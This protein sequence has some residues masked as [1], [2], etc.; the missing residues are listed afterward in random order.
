LLD[1]L[2]LAQQL[3]DWFILF[4]NTTVHTSSPDDIELQVKVWIAIFGIIT[5]VI[6]GLFRWLKRRL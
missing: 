1:G 2:K 4:L 5:G 3:I 6:A